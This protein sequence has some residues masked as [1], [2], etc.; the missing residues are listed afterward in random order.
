MDYPGNF[1][2]SPD[3]LAVVWQLLSSS[4]WVVVRQSLGSHRTI[5]RQPSGIC[6][7]AV[8]QLSGSWQTIGGK[9]SGSFQAVFRQ[10]SGS[11]QAVIRQANSAVDEKINQWFQGTPE[12]FLVNRGRGRG[13]TGISLQGTFPD[14]N[15]F[16]GMKRGQSPVVP[17]FRG[18][19]GDCTFNG[20]VLSIILV[21]GARIM[22][23]SKC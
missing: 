8:R 11:C 14:Y 5:V 20:F 17:Y 1:R 21:R 7:A 15:N 13:Q 4:C 3:I 23:Y 16:P 19:E 10:L 22:S 9:L 6:Q 2:W 12:S 18:G